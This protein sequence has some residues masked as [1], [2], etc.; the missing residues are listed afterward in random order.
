VTKSSELETEWKGKGE[1]KD[2]DTATPHPFCPV[3]PGLHSYFPGDEPYPLHTFFTCLPFLTG[4]K[5][6]HSHEREEIR[7]AFL[8]PFFVSGLLTELGP[9]PHFPPVTP[10][11]R[12]H[13]LFL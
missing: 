2:R 10:I 5:I 3:F 7:S 12:T 1:T 9:S 8:L 13:R 6:R 4:R 11:T